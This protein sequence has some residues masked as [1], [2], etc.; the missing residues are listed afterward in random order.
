MEVMVAVQSG[1]LLHALRVQLKRR[2][3]QRHEFFVSHETGLAGKLYLS[4]SQVETKHLDF[5]GFFRVSFQF[6]PSK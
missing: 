6:R 4:V 2:V 5:Q 1:T 3:S